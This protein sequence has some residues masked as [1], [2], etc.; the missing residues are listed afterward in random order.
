MRELSLGAMIANVILTAIL[1][2]FFPFLFSVLE[3]MKTKRK[4]KISCWIVNFF[5]SYAMHLVSSDQSYYRSIPY[6]IWTI[7]FVSIFISKVDQRE[8][9]QNM[10]R[11]S[12]E[13]LPE[14][15]PRETRV[16]TSHRKTQKKPLSL[17]EWIA[18]FAIVL[19]WVFIV[20]AVRQNV[21]QP[22]PTATPKPTARLVTP[23]PKPTVK[24]APAQVMPSNGYIF[25][26][27]TYV[28][29]CP[30]TVSV[31]GEN[32]YYVRLKYMYKPDSYNSRHT[33][34]NPSVLIDDYEFFV[35][36]GQTVELEVPVGVYKLYYATGTEWYG[37]AKLFGEDTGYFTSNELLS[38]FT[39]YTTFYGHTLELWLQSGGNFDTH[40][41]D[42]G[43]FFG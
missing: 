18:I 6:I 28:K 24:A 23:T 22:E 10:K 21:S 31:M 8:R 40:E 7:I 30:L 3:N 4:Y 32:G 17:Q 16:N 43:E 27:P 15:S 41:I 37:R 25:K 14:A 42:S 38:F 33:E 12:L 29:L 13:E 35:R 36:P 34:G 2:S 39:D 9:I 5:V 26:D 1:Y 20:F 11:Q 19:V